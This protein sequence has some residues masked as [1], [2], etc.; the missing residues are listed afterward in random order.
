MRMWTALRRHG[1]RY[2]PCAAGIG[3]A[4]APAGSQ[5]GP[6]RTRMRRAT[7]Q[8]TRS[9]GRAGGGRAPGQ[10]PVPVVTFRSVEKPPQVP[11]ASLARIR[12]RWVTPAS[13]PA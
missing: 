11:S 5:Q 2:I 10:R 8:V 9:P 3:N 12:T 13:R 6:G 1:R 7:G 4:R